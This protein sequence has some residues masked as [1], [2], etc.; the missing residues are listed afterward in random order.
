L[1]EKTWK[2]C[3]GLAKSLPVFK[4]LTYFLTANEN[5]IWRRIYEEEDPLAIPLPV[6]YA[7]LTEF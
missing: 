2:S 3:I 4:D 7:K 5:N 6:D 1:N